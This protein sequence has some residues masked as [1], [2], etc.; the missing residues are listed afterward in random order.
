MTGATGMV[1]AHVLAI[2]MRPD[3]DGGRQRHVAVLVR[4]RQLGRRTIDAADRIDAVLE[5]F[6]TRWGVR[7]LRPRIVR[8]ELNADGLGLSSEDDRWLREHCDEVLHSAA[9][10]NFAPA[11]DDPNGEPIRTNVDGT[12]NLLRWMQSAEVDRLHHVSTA[13][14]CG[15]RDGRIL[16]NDLDLQNDSD[17]AK[18]ADHASPTR[19]ANDYELSKATAERNVAAV[20]SRERLTIM[21]P[22]IVVDPTGLSPVS[23]DRTIYGAHAM[24]Q[25]LASRFGLPGPSVWMRQLGFDD[26]HRKNLVDAA[27]VAEAIVAIVDHP[28]HHGRNYHLTTPGGTSVTDLDAAFREETRRWLE[29]RSRHN[30]VVTPSHQP[31]DVRA[32]IDRVAAPFVQTFLPY[33]RDDPIFDQTNLDRVIQS[34]LRR[35]PAIGRAALTGMIR[36]WSPAP[37]PGVR[38]DRKPAS[39]SKRPPQIAASPGDAASPN[40]AASPATAASTR[41][42]E[43]FENASDDDL[44]ICSY[45]VRLPGGVNDVDDFRRLL[46]EGRSAIGEMPPERLDRDLY[47]DSRRGIPGRTY[48]AL[49]GVVDETPLDESLARRIESLGRYD[50]THRQFAAVAHAAFQ[51]LVETSDDVDG[52]RGGIFVGHSGGT[53]SGGPLAMSLQ[54]DAVASLL[55][56]TELADRGSP[57][58]VAKFAD[59]VADQIRSGRPDPDSD[60]SGPRSDGDKADP[61]YDAYQVASL[62]GHLTGIRGVREVIDAACSSSLIALSHASLLIRSSHIDFALVG[63]ATFNNVDNLALF[64]QSMACSDDGAFPFD[65]RA[66]GLI[67]SEGYVAVVVARRDFARRQGWPVEAIVRGVGCSSDGKGK[68]LWAPQSVGQRAAMRAGARDAGDAEPLDVDYV[69]CHATSTQVGDATELESLDALLNW[70]RSDCGEPLAIGSAKSNLGHLLEAAGLVGLVKVLLAMREDRLPPSINFAEPTD[71]FDWDGSRL[72]VVDQVSDW[73]RRKSGDPN[74]S[75]NPDANDGSGVRRAAVNAFG[76][77]GLNGHA[78]VHGGNLDSPSDRSSESNHGPNGP[79]RIQTVPLAIVGRGLRLPGAGDVDLFRKRLMDG[80]SALSPPPAGRW[81]IDPVGGGLI[82]VGGRVPHAIGGYVDGFVFD[83]QSYRIP[84]KSVA[85]ANPAQLMLIRAVTDAIGEYEQSGRWAELDRRRVGVAVGTIFGGQFSNELQVG[86]R[87]PELRRHVAETLRKSG[88]DASLCDRIAGQ[89]ADRVAERYTALLDETGGFTASTL[90]SSIARVN[91][92]GGGAYAVDADQS[93]SALALLTSAAR[94]AAGEIDVAIVASAHRSNDVVCVSQLCRR[95]QLVRSGDPADLPNDASK[96]FPGE[97]VATIVLMRL[98]DAVR[99]GQ[100][101]FGV[102]DEFATHPVGQAAAIDQSATDPSATDPSNRGKPAVDPY[103]I[104][105]DRALVS[106]FGHL[107]GGQ[108]LIQIIAE[109][110]NEWSESDST[111]QTLS[112]LSQS[113]VASA[114]DGFAISM[115]YRRDASVQRSDENLEPPLTQPFLTEAIPNE[116]TKRSAT[117]TVSDTI[118]LSPSESASFIAAEPMASATNA[119]HAADLCCFAGTRDEVLAGLRQF[120]EN[121]IAENQSGQTRTDHAA[122]GNASLFDHAV[123]LDHAVR[124]DGEIWHAAIAGDSETMAKAAAGLLRRCGDASTAAVATAGGWMRRKSIDERIGWLFPGQGSQ[125]A[126]KPRCFSDAFTGDSNHPADVQLAEF[127]AALFE[128]NLPGLTD[129]IDDPDAMLGRDIWF[130][131]AWVLG[132][133]MAMMASLR[134]AGMRPD[135]VAGHS[136]GEC[137]AAWAA[138]AMTT[139]TAIDFAKYRSDAVATSS[140]SD[141]TLLSVRAPATTVAA[142]LSHHAITITH[143]NAPEQTVVAASRG[144]IDAIRKTLNASRIASVIIPVPAAYHTPSMQTPRDLL[145]ARFDSAS[146]RPPH[147]G[148]LSAIS[149]RYLAEPRDV[150][151]NLIDQLIRPVQFSG[152][153]DRLIRDGVDVFIEVGPSDVLSKLATAAAGGRALVLAQDDPAIDFA[154]TSQLIVAA[155]ASVRRTPSNRPRVIANTPRPNSSSP[156]NDN[157]TESTATKTPSNNDDPFA[158]VD[159]TARSRRKHVSRSTDPSTSHR[160]GNGAVVP[161]VNESP[162]ADRSELIGGLDLLSSL[163]T[164]SDAPSASAQNGV[165]TPAT[166][167]QTASA[168]AEIGGGFASDADSTDSD[169]LRQM[170]VDL[171]VDQTG[172]E[173]DLIDMDADLEGELG[174]DSIKRAQLLGE[175]ETQYDLQSL[176]DQNLRLSDFPTL[177][178]IHAYVLDHIRSKKKA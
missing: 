125:Y 17:D 43:N 78:I 117:P 30:P 156:R 147:C 34:G 74:A 46:F 25:S 51:S 118:A 59:R 133:S 63:G 48:T 129:V 47:F 56:Q 82:D 145:A 53:Q 28:E 148:L 69:E 84:P 64:S 144:D 108:T 89:F 121:R 143:I 73:P 172:Y 14:V 22:S 113:I 79:R 159:V 137:T 18:R 80:E 149:L 57:E 111:P 124:P 8:G 178:S 162:I 101:I 135:V 165:A 106:T 155:D 5:P 166:S 93:S 174:I 13:Y 21:R 45:A 122:V 24:Y 49:G 58:A 160:T 105:R 1:G 132:V 134:A 91:D 70:R 9:S 112:N 33:F 52:R 163:S 26:N 72:R 10:L 170:I 130:T 115:R 83:A 19:F 177:G 175:L 176:R 32:Q 139:Q 95:D 141:Q 44:V 138:G 54:A 77:G 75:N 37:G 152:A 86:L 157:V 161:P 87:I 104:A 23:G 158:V 85:H 7:L 94:L 153:I 35:P 167:P 67:S 127:D 6:E 96:V 4:D 131:Q 102:L 42:G 3:A 76:I 12:N 60:A 128:R 171:I 99:R 40:T 15:L 55:H 27:W 62:A 29:K 169:R 11:A 164:P 65:R 38:P 120:A 103:A 119:D 140:G 16:E 36:S 2:W 41:A 71:R 123:R 173:E 136:F 66:S 68:A 146:C 97:G 107:G 50:L 88:A 61:R 39:K 126:A 151:D 109:T 92:L 154:I 98:D 31:D 150:L 90:A 114:D 20:I 81:P 116:E 168:T 100:R 110:E 142:T